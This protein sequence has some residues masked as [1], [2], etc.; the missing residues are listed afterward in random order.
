MEKNEQKDDKPVSDVFP[1]IFWGPIC[2]PARYHLS[3]SDE[4]LD[5]D[6]HAATQRH[7]A[8][9]RP[10]VA[11]HQQHAILWSWRTNLDSGDRLAGGVS[12]EIS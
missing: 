9:L 1:E 5:P 2:V 8:T 12:L 10:G 11:V 6:H 4:L 7:E 3:P